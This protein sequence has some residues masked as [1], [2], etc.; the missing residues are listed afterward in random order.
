MRKVESYR[1]D[2]ESGEIIDTYY[3]NDKITKVSGETIDYLCSNKEINENKKYTMAIDNAL[4][5]ISTLGLTSSAYN[6]L[7]IMI[8]NLGFGSYS[9]Y[10]I[11][12]KNK[13][14]N[15]FMNGEEIRSLT[16][17]NKSTFLKAIKQLEHF[18]I[19]KQVKASKG[20]GNNFIVNPFIFT[21]NKLVPIEV[22]EMFEDSIF[23]YTKKKASLTT[24]SEIRRR[25]REEREKLQ[26]KRDNY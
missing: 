21:H 2:K 5:I 12:L 7:M 8:A 24:N 18:E 1:I 3:Y 11:K 25:I 14:F 16:N 26:E 22:V 23:N 4:K 15:G 13:K 19:I 20:R 9:N 17:C 10:V 6:V